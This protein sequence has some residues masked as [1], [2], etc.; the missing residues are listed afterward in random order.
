MSKH[1]NYRM[2]CRNPRCGGEFLRRYSV[3]EFDELQYGGAV[4]G[5]SCYNCGFPKMAVMRSNAVRRDKFQ[6][7]F[8]RNIMKYCETETQYKNYLKEMGLVEFTYDDLP[9]NTENPN[10]I[11]YWTDEILKKVYDHGVHFSGEEAR[12]LKEGLE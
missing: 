12:A 9:K 3:E 10:K 11:N 7:G 8:K 6:P 5:I 4:K 1:E 2:K